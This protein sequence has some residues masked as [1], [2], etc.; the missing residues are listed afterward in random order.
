MVGVCPHIEIDNGIPYIAGTPM[1]IEGL[2]M[3]HLNFDWDGK[4]LQEQFPRLTL[5]QVY[6]ALGYYY[7]HKEAMDAEIERKEREAETLRPLLENPETRARLMAAKRALAE[8][9]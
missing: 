9:L 8:R 2:V 3:N 6:A 4:E 7:D 1:K 5:G